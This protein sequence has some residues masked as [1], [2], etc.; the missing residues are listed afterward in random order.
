MNT[1]KIVLEG[2]GLPT[3]EFVSLEEFKRRCTDLKLNYKEV[4]RIE[5]YNGFVVEC[6]VKD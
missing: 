6:E 5:Y 4:D 1:I 2:N 3:T